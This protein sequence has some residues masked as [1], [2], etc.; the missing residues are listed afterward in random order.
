MA[1]CP[2]LQYVREIACGAEHML[3][4][5]RSNVF[6][7]GNG[8][9]MRLGHGDNAHRWGPTVIERSVERMWHRRSGVPSQSGSYC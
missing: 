8:A 5:T 3:A 2:Y 6:S 4:L 1:G 9:G 7:W